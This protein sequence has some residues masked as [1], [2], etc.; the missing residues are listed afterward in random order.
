MKSTFYYGSHYLGVAD[1]IK[2]YINSSPEFLSQQTVGSPR[3]V[4]MRLRHYWQRNLTLFWVI[5]APSIQ[6]TLRGA[7]WQI[8][9]L[10]TT[11]VSILL[12]M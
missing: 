3:A 8:S 4:G 5:G 7:Q 9:R 1:G 6:V 11:M 10:L 2:N 12:L